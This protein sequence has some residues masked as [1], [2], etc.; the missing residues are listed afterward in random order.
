MQ[1]QELRCPNC[2]RMLYLSDIQGLMLKGSIK[3]RCKRCGHWLRIEPN[4]NWH[5]YIIPKPEKPEQI[6]DPKRR[7]DDDQD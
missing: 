7:G 2:R 3:T 4:T 6:F 1:E 5:V